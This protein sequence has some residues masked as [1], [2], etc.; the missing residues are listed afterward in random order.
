HLA[1][2]HHSKGNSTASAAYSTLL[3]RRPAN[4]TADMPSSASNVLELVPRKSTQG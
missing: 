2:N 3:L 4:A 1:A